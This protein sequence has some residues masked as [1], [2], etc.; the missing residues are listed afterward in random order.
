VFINPPKGSLHEHTFKKEIP[1]HVLHALALSTFFGHE[2][3][4][5]RR[6]DPIDITRKYLK[7]LLGCSAVH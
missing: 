3:R 2:D 7:T 6:N 1:D 4:H 5:W